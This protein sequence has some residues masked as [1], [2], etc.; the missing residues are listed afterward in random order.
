MSDP[1]ALRA[2]TADSAS[3]AL[4]SDIHYGEFMDLMNALE[5]ELQKDSFVVSM[6]DLVEKCC[7]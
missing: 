7:K 1:Y 5:V 2:C 6:D 3:V 4:V